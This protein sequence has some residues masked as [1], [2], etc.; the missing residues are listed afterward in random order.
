[1]KHTYTHTQQN[2]SGRGIGPSRRPLPDNIQHSQA[3]DIHATDGILIRNRSTRASAN[4]RLRPRS[5]RDRPDQLSDKTY[6]V[7]TSLPTFRQEND[8]YSCISSD[9]GNVFIRRSRPVIQSCKY[10]RP[11]CPAAIKI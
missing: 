4:S 1:M 8:F 2:S 3:T 5:R 9:Y 11:Y 7:P 10:Y 6:N